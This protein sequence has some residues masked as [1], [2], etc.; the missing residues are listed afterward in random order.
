M[1]KLLN[2]PDDSLTK[3]I[4]LTQDL[5][6]LFVKYQIP[7]DLIS[8]DGQDAETVS[9]KIAA[10]RKYADNMMEMVR[11]EKEA[12]LE[13]A[14]IA[15]ALER[16]LSAAAARRVPCG[17]TSGPRP[18]TGLQGYSRPITFPSPVV[19][20][21]TTTAAQQKFQQRFTYTSDLVRSESENKADLDYTILP[22]ELEK[23]LEAF[24]ANSLRPTII[25]PG[26][27]WTKS[28]HKSI[29]APQETKSIYPS[30]LKI[31]RDGAF[32]LLDAL[33][34]SGVLAIDHASL[35]VVIASTHCFAKSIVDT[36][37]QD[38]VNPI[39]KVE[40]SA[41]VVA[42]TIHRARIEDL[43]E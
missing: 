27:E 18:S 25:N 14:R 28:F 8:Y 34:K 3:E 21:A 15:L 16:K 30:D 13:A 23:K 12:Q 17:V 9:Y 4:Q 2:L 29:L 22:T 20:A 10:V 41:L 37:V 42:S 6:Q 5:L 36:I 26:D 1:E 31:E 7:S 19:K 39:E 38:N 43:I 40:N 35:H 24:E 32:D 11:K 33:T